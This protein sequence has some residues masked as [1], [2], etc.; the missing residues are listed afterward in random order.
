MLE[1]STYTYIHEAWST[2][3][4]LDHVLTTV[5]SH[6][7]IDNVCVLYEYVSSDHHPMMISLKCDKHVAFVN[8]SDNASGRKVIRWSELDMVRILKYTEKN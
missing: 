3:H 2:V 1:N 6:K 4:W 8:Q 5:N 7:L